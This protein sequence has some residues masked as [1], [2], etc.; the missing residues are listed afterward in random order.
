MVKYLRENGVDI[1]FYLDDG[2]GMSEGYSECQNISEFIRS[3]LEL[4]GFLI[5]EHKSIFDPVQCLKWLGLIW[6]SVIFILAVSKRRLNDTKE[7]LDNIL[8]KVPIISARQ[9]AQFTGRII[10]TCMSP[11]MRTVTSLV[12][13]HLYFAIENTKSWDSVF[14]IA[15]TKCVL[16]EELRFWSDS[17]TNL[18]QKK[19]VNDTS[20]N[21]VMYSDAGNL[22]ACA[23][24]VE[25]NEKVCHSTWREYDKNM[26]ST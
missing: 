16:A 18:N 5:N 15:Y 2:L 6:D 13:R 22:A 24:T 26:S 19:F 9:L 10:H 8:K 20:S 14:D 4:A 7:S 12:T 17:L 23:L 3:S 1:M 21:I 11:V 25:V